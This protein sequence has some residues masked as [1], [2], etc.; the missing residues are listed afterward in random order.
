MCV[1]QVP[2]AGHGR[3]FMTTPRLEADLEIDITAEICPMTF[4]RARLALDRLTPGQLLGVT[5]RGA[6]PARNVP[7]TARLQ[8]HDV[9]ETVKLGDGSLRLLIRKK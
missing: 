6:E 8:G 5:L 2:A 3:H 7:E 4:V 1:P 9:L